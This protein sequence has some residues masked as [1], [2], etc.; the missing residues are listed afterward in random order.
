[1]SPP[2]ALGMRALMD[3]ELSGREH[4]PA[5]GPYIVTANHL[6]LMDPVLVTAAVGRLIR[7]LALDELFGQSVL[8]DRWMLYFGSIPVSRD[9]PP[10]GAMKQALRVLEKGDVLGIFPEG[11]RALYWGERTIKKGAAWL[12][13]AT[14]A[15]VVPCSVIGTEATL[16]LA[17][18][19][20]RVPAVKLHVHPPLYPDSYIDHE[21]PLG[22]MMGDWA[23]AIDE[24]IQHWQHKE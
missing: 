5:D 8:L 9:R 4:V 22:S 1:M 15:P 2:V 24:R 16:S 20:I 17:E 12:S 10:L 14:G 3:A 6:S 21:D 13:I 23:S 18:P 19:G 7:F 11:A